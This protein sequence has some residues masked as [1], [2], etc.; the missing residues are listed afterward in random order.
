MSKLVCNAD[1]DGIKHV[2]AMLYHQEVIVF[3]INDVFGLLTRH[4]TNGDVEDCQ[5]LVDEVAGR[6]HQVC[7][8]VMGFDHTNWQ[9][10]SE[11]QREEFENT[12]ASVYCATMDAVQML[13]TDVVMNLPACVEPKGIGQFNNRSMTY[14]I[15]F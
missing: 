10:M 1:R 11:D 7:M 2:E 15:E 13:H 14:V 6:A 9:V 12:T 5:P 4:W 8:Q 3:D